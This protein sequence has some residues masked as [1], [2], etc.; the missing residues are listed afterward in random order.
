MKFNPAEGHVRCVYP[1]ALFWVLLTAMGLIKV[2][3][4]P[5][6]ARNGSNDGNIDELWQLQASPILPLLELPVPPMQ[7][8]ATEHT[9]LIAAAGCGRQS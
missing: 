1:V 9:H 4:M 6:V 2:Q 5:T 7:Y 8:R 3:V